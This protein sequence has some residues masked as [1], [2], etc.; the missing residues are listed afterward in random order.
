MALTRPT[1]CPRQSPVPF[2]LLLLCWGANAAQAVPSGTVL[3]WGRNTEN[4]SA[5]PAAAQSGV[6]AI[7]AATYYTIALTTNGSVLAWGLLGAAPA[8]VPPVAQSGVIA[9]AA[10]GNF[11]LALK[12]DGS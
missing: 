10:G 8:S 1:S 7:A 2:L 5:V 4:Q 11:C 9:I 12:I 6:V 3:A